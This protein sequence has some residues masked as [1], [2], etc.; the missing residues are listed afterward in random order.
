MPTSHPQR[1]VTR[2]FTNLSR[3]PSV[4]KGNEP[5]AL[6]PQ[7]PATPW[8]DR[9]LGRHSPITPPSQAE[10]DAL[11]PKERQEL[12][13]A[14]HQRPLQTLTTFVTSAGVLLSI[15][16]TAYG[17][18]YTSQ[19]LRAT[20][21]G[22]ITDRYTKAVEQLGSPAVDVRLGA[23]YA[24]RRIAID[25]PRDR[26]TIRDVLVAFVRNHDLCSI[27]KPP[28]QCKEKLI[29]DLSR[30]SSVRLATDVYAALA[31]VPMLT[32]IYDIP[33]DFSQVRLP[34]AL[35]SRV[36][37][38]G[39]SLT[40]ANLTNAYLRRANLSGAYMIYT[41]LSGADLIDVN[42]TGAYLAGADLTSAYLN[43]ANLT[44][45]NLIEANLKKASLR[46]ANLAA[47]NLR[48]A[49]LTDANLTDA[50][51][52]GANLTGANLIGANLARVRGITPDKIREVAITDS[53][54]KF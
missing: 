42:L 40:E 36:N 10:L 13:D 46:Y 15:V 38:S 7:P 22:Q 47:A 45:V 25:S 11:S 23:I 5:P 43:Y 49:Q 33:S 4:P 3:R 28:K 16:L 29:E 2:T 1:R 35:L 12:L 17:F 39:V 54:T 37:L 53:T 31:S 9:I 26:V 18:S 32:T 19:T 41:N 34:K 14:R 51:L 52:T 21:E 30:T 24:L 8:F 6:S 50:N 20:Q 27:K 48:G 44:K